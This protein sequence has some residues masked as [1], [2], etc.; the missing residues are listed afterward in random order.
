MNGRHDFSMNWR[1][2]S[3]N[4]FHGEV[5][6]FQPDQM[7]ISEAFQVWL[8]PTLATAAAPSRV[9]LDPPYTDPVESLAV[10]YNNPQSRWHAAAI[11]QGERCSSSEGRC[12]DA[13]FVI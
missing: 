1:D 11:R 8:S 10:R 2:R 5:N 12:R 13:A 6:G 9:A 3:T 7:V 4:G